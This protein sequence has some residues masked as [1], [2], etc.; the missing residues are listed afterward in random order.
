MNA[1]SFFD[2]LRVEA[3]HRARHTTCIPV[4]ID[5]CIFSRQKWIRARWNL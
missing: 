1:Q 2:V 4:Q 5:E 3:R